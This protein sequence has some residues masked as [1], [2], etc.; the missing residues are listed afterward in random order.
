MKKGLF[1]SAIGAATVASAYVLKDEKRR[2][3]VKDKMVEVKQKYEQSMQSNKTINQPLEKAGVPELD[4]VENTKMV[5]E[6]SQ[7]GVQYY[8]QI[9]EKE[10]QSTKNA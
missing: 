7:F 4:C 6:G 10:E 2:Q 3:Q 9:K 5:D 1:L 8:N